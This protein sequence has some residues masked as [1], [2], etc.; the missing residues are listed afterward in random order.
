[1]TRRW[2]CR[3]GLHRERRLRSPGGGWYA[4]CMRC[5]RDRDVR[6]KLVM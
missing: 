4:R 6:A 3:L 5:G 1:M 2:L